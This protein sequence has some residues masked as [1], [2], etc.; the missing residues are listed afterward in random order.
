MIESLQSW[1]ASHV[2]N[3]DCGQRLLHDIDFIRVW[4]ELQGNE[5]DGSEHRRLL[6]SAYITCEPSAQVERRAKAVEM[7]IRLGSLWLATELKAT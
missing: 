4:D 3:C 2:A 6:P 1:I 7:K 5:G